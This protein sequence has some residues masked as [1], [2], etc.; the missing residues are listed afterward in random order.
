MSIGCCCFLVKATI[1]FRVSSDNDPC[2]AEYASNLIDLEA[3]LF[4]KIH[5]QHEEVSEEEVLQY[6][7]T[8]RARASLIKKESG[9]NPKASSVFTDA[10]VEMIR[11]LLVNSD[12]Q[13]SH[14]A[15]CLCS[16]NELID[17]LRGNPPRDALQPEIFGFNSWGEFVAALDNAKKGY[18]TFTDI[19]KFWGEF[20][21]VGVLLEL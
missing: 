4:R 13:S 2:Q 16:N 10:F 5:G 6:P 11:Y 12:L 15:Y 8:E 21:V 20:S 7:A 19:C 3:E 18:I 14:H 9:I 1:G 17:K